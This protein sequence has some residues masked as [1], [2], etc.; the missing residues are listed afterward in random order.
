MNP[1]IHLLDLG[2]EIDSTMLDALMKSQGRSELVRGILQT[3]RNTA[4]YAATT[5]PDGIEGKNDAVIYANLGSYRG[6]SEVLLDLYN[7]TTVTES[8]KERDDDMLSEVP[9][10]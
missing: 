9:R 8:D 7:K 1:P 4:L 5:A 2:P 6:L 3:L 10:V